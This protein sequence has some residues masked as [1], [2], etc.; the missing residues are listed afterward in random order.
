MFSSSSAASSLRLLPAAATGGV[1]ICGAWRVA[2]LSC[3][4][5]RLFAVRK[6]PLDVLGRPNARAVAAAAAAAAASVSAAATPTATNKPRLE[7]SDFHRDRLKLDTSK[8]PIP[9]LRQR[10]APDNARQSPIGS[11]LARRRAHAA[12]SE[13]S[14]APRDLGKS[15]DVMLGKPLRS[16]AAAPAD[17]A[18]DG[19]QPLVC[20]WNKLKL[21]PELRNFI[22]LQRYEK[23]T[24]IQVSPRQ[25]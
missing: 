8:A 20:D 10:T 11:L 12:E 5:L 22:D 25:T 15:S 1:R 21:R 13:R 17:R 23:P 24:E 16:S 2:P 7:L 18:A 19:A 9:K 14:V 4:F 6:V 3:V